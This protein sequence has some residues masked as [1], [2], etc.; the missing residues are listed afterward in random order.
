MI[1]DAKTNY[2]YL[3][4][5]L[6]KKYPEF[7][8][9]FQIILSELA[10]GRSLLPNTKDVWAVDYM[11]I[12]IAENKFVQFDYDPDYLQ[13]K[14]LQKTISNVDEICKII[15]IETEKSNIKIDGGNV[16]RNSNKVIMCDKILNEN[17]H[18]K[19][20]LLVEELTNLFQIEVLIFIP[21]DP[22]D[23]I[24]H[25]DGMVRF[26]NDKTVLINGY[27]KEDFVLEQSV[28]SSINNAGLDW[29]EIPY[30]PYNNKK[31]FHANGIYMNFLQMENVLVIPTFNIKED[32]IAVRFFEDNF[33]DY[34]IKTLESNEIA[35]NGGVLNCITWNI[36]V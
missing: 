21:T 35:Y 9:R 3:A 17:K 6:P 34:T 28:K 23:E 18:L 27:A 10:I 22:L 26:I 7:Y 20:E 32:E 11:P 4:D 12:Q 31:N 8:S 1:I 19:K 15:G 16:I 36:K 24:G 13:G 29:V 25:A 5:S 33:I 14:T 30:N 2:L